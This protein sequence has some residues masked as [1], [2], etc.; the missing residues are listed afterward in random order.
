MS[1]QTTNGASNHNGAVIERVVA[2]GDLDGLQPIER[3]RYYSQVCESVGLNPLTRPFAYIRLNGK[4]TLY[5][6]RDA[7]DQLRKLYT[8]SVVIVSRE[9][10]DDLCIV[11]AR[12]TMP[13]GR[14]DESTGAVALGNLKGEALANAL[15]KAET[16]AKRRVTLSICG[17]GWLDETEVADVRTAKSV[18]VTPDGEIVE[19]KPEPPVQSDLTKQLSASVDWVRWAQDFVK[20]V[21]AAATKGAVNEVALVVGEEAKRLAAPEE[22]LAVV[23]QAIRDRKAEL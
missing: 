22:A 13:D 15:M 11:T 4:L 23:R 8:V 6:L 1:M 12:A 17:L 20:E 14:T 18:T 21:Q 16:K 7:T 10:V 2:M 9:K 3:A 19:A 5:A